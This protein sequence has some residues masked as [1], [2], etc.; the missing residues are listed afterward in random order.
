M[1]QLLYFNFLANHNKKWRKE[2]N[3]PNIFSR[4]IKPKP[5]TLVLSRAQIFAW[6]WSLETYLI[7]QVITTGRFNS[8]RTTVFFFVLICP[9]TNR[10]KAIEKKTKVIR[11]KKSRHK[12]KWYSFFI[13]DSK[14]SEIFVDKFMKN[15]ICKK[16]INCYL[17]ERLP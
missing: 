17:Q 6:V 16:I 14:Y 13:Y 9:L 8:L 4:K 12:R 5:T 2:K 15:Y 3:A 7:W 10:K 11:K 1:Q